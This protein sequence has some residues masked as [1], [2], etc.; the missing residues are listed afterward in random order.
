MGKQKENVMSRSKRILSA[1]GVVFVTAWIS[2]VI[3]IL[4]TGEMPRIYAAT[5]LVQVSNETCTAC[6][7]SAKHDPYF[8]K[9]QREIIRSTPVIEEVVRELNLNEILGRA[10]GY[11]VRINAEANFDRTV[12]L[13]KEK[14]SVHI[15]RD[16]DL[17][18]ITVKLDKPNDRPNQAAVTAAEIANQIAQSFKSLDARKTKMVKEDG[19][20]KLQQKLDAYSRLIAE[21]EQKVADAQAEDIVAA[22]TELEIMKGR[23]KA[24]EGR[25]PDERIKMIHPPEGVRIIQPA[26][27]VGEA[28]PVSPNITFNIML[29]ML[30]GLLLGCLFALPI[31]FGGKK[32]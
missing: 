6:G 27:V 21:Q 31:L 25:T 7:R 23:R 29:S 10:Y 30:I 20:A 14:T 9:T 11:Y 28:V 16:T 1:L 15:F 2:M 13:V 32:N 24:L 19:L 18:A 4:I 3:G 5:A 26:K 8:L 22:M 17:I 12:E